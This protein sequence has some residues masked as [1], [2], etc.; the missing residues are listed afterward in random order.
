MNRTFIN[1]NVVKMLV[2]CLQATIMVTVYYFLCGNLPLITTKP[3]A[4][5]LAEINGHQM[6]GE[7]PSNS[8]PMAVEIALVNFAVKVC[9]EKATP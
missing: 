8:I 2:F 4:I 5:G 1:K 9:T 3:G 7:K 6:R